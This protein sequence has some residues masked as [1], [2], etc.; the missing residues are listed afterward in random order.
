MLSKKKLG[1]FCSTGRWLRSGGRASPWPNLVE[2]D[3]ILLSHSELTLL[4]LSHLPALPRNHSYAPTACVITG[5]RRGLCGWW[6][7]GNVREPARTTLP[8]SET[9]HLSLGEAQ[10]LHMLQALKF[11]RSQ[12]SRFG[13][14]KSNMIHEL[15]GEHQCLIPPDAPGDWSR[16]WPAVD[17][18]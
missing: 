2:R 5:R 3:S 15:D 4:V 11:Q 18:P 17:A 8:S 6:R 9:S 14:H 7:G 1:K 13:A 10:K 12:S 16:A